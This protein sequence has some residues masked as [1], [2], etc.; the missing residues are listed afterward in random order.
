MYYLFKRKNDNEK[1]IGVFK[2]YQWTNRQHGDIDTYLSII[3]LYSDFR[4]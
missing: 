1:L 4:F 3:L 2:S